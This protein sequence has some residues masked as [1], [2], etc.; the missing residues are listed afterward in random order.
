MHELFSLAHS[1]VNRHPIPDTACSRLETTEMLPPGSSRF[2]WRLAFYR[3]CCWVNAGM[4]C[5]CLMKIAK[6][7][8]CISQSVHLSAWECC[9]T[10]QHSHALKWTDPG[11]SSCS[12]C[13]VQPPVHRSPLL[14]AEY[15]I[16]VPGSRVEL[17][18]CYRRLRPH[19]RLWRPSALESR[20]SF[21]WNH[22]Q[23][24]SWSDILFLHSV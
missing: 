23:T 18:A 16:L 3:M 6:T 4:D 20:R 15:L 21:S 12:D 19:D 5:M 7:P 17:H 22:I 2:M 1:L 10:L 11:L 8:G 9:S 14:A 13:L 24:F